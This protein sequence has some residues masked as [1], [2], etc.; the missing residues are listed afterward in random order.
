M[1]IAA[2]TAFQPYLLKT[3]LDSV[4]LNLGKHNLWHGS[5][6]PAILLL[7]L[8]IL[9]VLFWRLNNYLVLK[10]LPNLKAD[11]IAEASDYT[12]GQSYRFFQDNLSGAMS[13]KILDLASN[14]DNLIFNSRSLFISSFAFFSSILV[15]MMVNG[16]FAVLYVVWTCVFIGTAFIFSNRM[17]KYSN[18]FAEFR[19]FTF[20][21]VV[22]SF[23]NAFNVMLFARKNYERKY[24]KTSLDAMVDKDKELQVKFIKYGFVLS[25]LTVIIQAVTIA[26]LLY[27]GGAGLLT[28]GDF[29]LIFLL[30]VNII[31]HVWNFAEVLLKVS[32]QYGVFK[33][34][35]EFISKPYTVM[36]D[37]TNPRIVITEG[38]IKF[39]DV[40]FTFQEKNILFEDKSILI[41]G[42]E[43]V[44]LVGYSGAGKSTFVNLI[45]RI[46]DVE[47]GDISID[48]Q[49]IYS[50]DL[51]S[52]R[53][54]ISYIPQDPTLFHRTIFENIQYGKLDATFDE[55]VVAAKKAHVH[56]FVNELPAAYDSLVGERGLK[57]SGGQRQRIAIARAILKDAPILIL[58]EATSSL[59][60]STEAL[61]Q[62]SLK[63]AMQKKTVLTIAHR[64]STVKAMDRILVFDKG[65][66]VESGSHDELL[67]KGAV[68]QNL[69]AKQQGFI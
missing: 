5:L 9:N 20:G 18:V 26:L 63:V 47:K 37:H 43:K 30:T 15:A 36:N 54:N 57:L 19:S 6:L 21:K 12:H 41:H 31:D 61:I 56:E 42:K 25:G 14:T 68:Y 67:E 39:T 69:W 10:T 45:M 11:I 60:S 8:T 16:Y 13:N 38:S 49:S 62:D 24:L 7:F 34:G 33:Q 23:A 53:E 1:V 35:L 32:E 2:F 27:F 64:L 52:L 29:V 4:T 44:G 66:I 51:D 46:F 22:D 17:N 59:D 50:V 48:D 58:D 65:K 3:F 28:V 40:K 55:V